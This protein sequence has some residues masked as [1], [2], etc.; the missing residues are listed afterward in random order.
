M[1]RKDEDR[2][3]GAEGQERDA[4][5]ILPKGV[6]CRGASSS[7]AD[8]PPSSA[9]TKGSESTGSARKIMTR[10]NS[11]ESRSNGALRIGGYSPD[12]PASTDYAR[13]RMR[14]I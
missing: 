6:S 13:K 3:V 1:L 11:H 7:R 5:Q 8:K 10:S 14:H 12:L 4:I 2:S 9:R